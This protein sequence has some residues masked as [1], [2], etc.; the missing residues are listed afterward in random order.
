VEL[1]HELIIS[2][3]S[4]YRERSVGV[5]Q[6]LKK[7]SPLL[8]FSGITIAGLTLEL[9]L[10]LIVWLL[11]RLFRVETDFWALTE[12]LAT[13]TAAA[14]VLGGG[15]V[16]YRELNEISDSRHI[17]VANQLFSELNSLENINARRWVY[18]NLPED[19][20][21]GLNGLSSEGRSAVKQVLNS[22]DHV[23][24]LTQAGWIPED[25][26]M[27]WMQPM[28][29]KSWIKL[30]PYVM[31]ERQRRSEPYFYQYAANLAARCLAWRAKHLPGKE[32]IK[33]VDGAL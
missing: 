11:L 3:H 19:P 31:H 2:H 18:Q 33:W 23:A 13:A 25:M 24:F 16:A 8:I 26:V 30:E 6:I 21:E 12:A 5:K 7:L 32:T 15:Y 14:L 10:D 9:F 22:L 28:V 27:P 17:E 29:V 4:N 20:A 1:L